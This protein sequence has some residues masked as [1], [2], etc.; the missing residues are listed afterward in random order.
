[1][2]C[3]PRAGQGEVIRV[4]V[5]GNRVGGEGATLEP[6]TGKACLRRWRCLGVLMDVKDPA[7][8]TVSS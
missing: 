4:E 2:G 8:P 5:G 7:P 3:L 6:R 1:M